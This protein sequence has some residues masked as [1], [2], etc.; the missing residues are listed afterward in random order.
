MTAK[1]AER[2][3]V[4]SPGMRI[5]PITAFG[6]LNY[7]GGPVNLLPLYPSKPGRFC[8][9]RTLG[10]RAYCPLRNRARVLRRAIPAASRLASKLIAMPAYATDVPWGCRAMPSN[11]PNSLP[12]I[13]S[14]S[15][16]VPS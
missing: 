1:V 5:V 13:G 16:S 3:A 15:R 10:L 6:A 2:E 11:T 12:L 7:P 9:V 14:H 8:G 4:G